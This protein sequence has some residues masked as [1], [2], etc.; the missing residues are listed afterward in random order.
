MAGKVTPLQVAIIASGGGQLRDCRS[1]DC[2]W[3]ELISAYMPEELERRWR[4]IIVGC[5]K[6]LGK[7]AGI[8]AAGDQL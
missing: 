2:S 3:R 7:E 1:V 8:E 5:T 4:N 6:T